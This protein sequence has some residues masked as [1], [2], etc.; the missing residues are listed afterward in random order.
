MEN[1]QIQDHQIHSSSHTGPN[2]LSANGRLNAQEYYWLKSENDSNPWFQVDFLENTT[3]SEIATEA[4][5][6]WVKTYTL[7][8]SND[9]TNFEEHQEDGITK[10]IYHVSVSFFHSIRLH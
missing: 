5:N 6:S 4:F 7:S 3:V 8:Y 1:G 2:Y 9:G 10:V